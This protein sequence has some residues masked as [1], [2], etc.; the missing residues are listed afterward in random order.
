[1]SLGILYTLLVVVG[2]GVEVVSSKIY[3]HITRKHLKKNHFAFGRYIFLLLFPL[4]GTIFVITIHGISLLKVFL[5]FAVIGPILEWLIGYSYFQIM[6]VRLWTYKKFTYQGHTSML[7][8]PLWGMAGVL[9]Y[10]LAAKLA[11]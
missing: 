9:F 10:L 7:T 1:M 6:G 11:L 4:V 8:M 3:F 2:V 5:L